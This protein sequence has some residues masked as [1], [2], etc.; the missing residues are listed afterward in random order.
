MKIGLSPQMKGKGEEGGMKEE[1]KSNKDFLKNASRL[2][3]TA[4]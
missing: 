1:R 3:E 2:H 4:K